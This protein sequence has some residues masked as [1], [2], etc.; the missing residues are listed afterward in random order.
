MT[1]KELNKLLSIIKAVKKITEQ[2]E[3]D[4][5]E[6]ENECKLRISEDVYDTICDYLDVDEIDLF[7]V[8]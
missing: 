2:Y 5:E 1:N 3:I 7:G 4:Y 8:T 6:D